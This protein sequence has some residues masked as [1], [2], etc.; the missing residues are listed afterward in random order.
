MQGSVNTSFAQSSALMSLPF[1]LLCTTRSELGGH[2]K[3]CI[4]ADFL[5]VELP[6]GSVVLFEAPES[7][8]V[9]MH[10]GRPEVEEVNAELGR[11]EGVARGAASLAQRM[12]EAVEPDEISLEVSLG[13]SGEVGWFFAKTSANG[14]VKMTLKWKK[15]D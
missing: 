9:S 14:A 5:R 13:L 3:G 2:R 1:V 7:D 6:D 12:R 10:G 15:D 8:L 11:L 4:V